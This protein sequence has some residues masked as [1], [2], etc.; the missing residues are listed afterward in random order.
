MRFF[1]PVLRGVREHHKLTPAAVGQAVGVSAS[2][3]LAI[4]KGA[5]PQLVNF[6]KL[7]KWIGIKPS[8][9]LDGEEAELCSTEPEKPATDA[10]DDFDQPEPADA[11]DG[12]RRN[13]LAPA[14]ML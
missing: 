9:F 14:G 2:T 3:I 10:A 6:L 5:M 7:C 1:G 11:L 4:E 8:T 13:G 12:V